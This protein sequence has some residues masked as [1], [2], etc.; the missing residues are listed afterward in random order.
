MSHHAKAPPVHK[1]F[2]GTYKMETMY[3]ELVKD[4]VLKMPKR[5]DLEKKYL[6]DLRTGKIK[7]VETKGLDRRPYTAHPLGRDK[8]SIG[9]DF[10]A[11]AVVTWAHR[12]DNIED[13]RPQVS[14]AVN[15]LRKPSKILLL[16]ERT[17]T[18]DPAPIPSPTSFAAAAASSSS[19]T[20]LS[21]THT[22]VPP[23]EPRASR[24]SWRRL[25]RREGRNSRPRQWSVRSMSRKR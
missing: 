23:N 9:G 13:E 6:E 24:A 15:Q 19:S 11:V 5:A 25:L 17:S 12:F 8:Q 18:N 21:T 10:G 4:L 20:S 16:H 7:N 3:Q 14:V 22:S 1:E 2:I